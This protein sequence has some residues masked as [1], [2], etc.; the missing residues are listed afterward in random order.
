MHYRIRQNKLN[1][2]IGQRNNALLII[3]GLFLLCLIQ[4][5]TIYHLVNENKT[6]FT[7][8]PPVISEPFS[9]SRDQV[10]SGY[11]ADMSRYFAMLRLNYTP[12]SLPNQ[13]KLLLRYTDGR[14]YGEF[15]Q[16]LLTEVEQAKT[17]DI[18]M[19]FMPVDTEVFDKK[20]IV[21]IKGDL[22][23]YVGKEALPVTRVTYRI[24]YAYE[25]GVL[26]VTSMLPVI[27]KSKEHGDEKHA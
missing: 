18:S 14:F 9:I 4:M 5:I 27:N 13:M 19:S 2:L 23:R 25:N 22:I 10:S 21:L 26:K 16:Q 12:A 3:S 17:N 24:T 15:K 20:L 1:Q 7:P 6:N 11:L 8:L